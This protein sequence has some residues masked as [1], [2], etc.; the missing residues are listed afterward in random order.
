MSTLT[1][2]LFAV[3]LG[4]VLL[5]SPAHGQT[6]VFSESFDD[7]SQFDVTTGSTGSDGTDNFFRITDGSSIDKSYVGVNGSF[8]AGQDHDDPDIG[9]Q[10]VRQIEWTGIDI[11]TKSNLYFNGSFGEVLDGSGDIDD[12]DSLVVAYRIDGGAYQNVIAFRNDGSSSNTNFREDTDFDGIGEGTK[13]SSDNGSLEFFA[14]E[15]SETGTTLD[16]RFTARIDSGD[17]DFAVDDF[18]IT[19]NGPLP[20]ELASFDVTLMVNRAHLTWRTASETNN[21]GFA[22]QHRSPNDV[23]WHRR[24]FVDGNGTTHRSRTYRFATGRLE[25]GVH[26]FRLKQI[27]ADGTVHFS[28]S[29]MLTVRGKRRLQIM[30]ASPLVKGQTAVVGVHAETRQMIEV[31]LYDVLGQRVRT[32]AAERM[33]PAQPMRA[34]IQTSDL[35]SGVYFLRAQGETFRSSQKFTVIR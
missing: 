26:R 16:L 33:G 21:V 31:A 10:P 5:A 7:T 34:R 4:V 29:R 11:S 9:G 30:S 8:L 6:T 35:A 13:I 12:D 25:S 14:K 15:I 24:G 2:P 20:V 27:D 19:A 28:E 18:S 1:H 17:E 22:V 23:E 3:L 32:V